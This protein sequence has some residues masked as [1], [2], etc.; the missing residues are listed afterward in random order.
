MLQ[1]RRS[2][3]PKTDGLPM[4]E[5]RTVTPRTVQ[6]STVRSYIAIVRSYP[7]PYA[8]SNVYSESNKQYSVATEPTRRWVLRMF[9][10]P[11][12]RRSASCAASLLCSRPQAGLELRLEVTRRLDV[13]L[14]DIQATLSHRG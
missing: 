12:A 6:S 4:H 13:G 8:T 3:F 11:H 1:L 9:L 2:L 7:Y 10:P 5:S 14:V